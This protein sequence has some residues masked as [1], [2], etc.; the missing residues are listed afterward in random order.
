MRRFVTTKV[1]GLGLSLSIAR[2]VIET[3][4]GKIWA[5][6][7]RQCGAIVSFLLPVV[8]MASDGVH[9]PDAAYS[10]SSPVLTGVE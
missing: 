10:T 8:A 5:E 6:N 9:P 1:E 2:T 4:G 3:H 7:G